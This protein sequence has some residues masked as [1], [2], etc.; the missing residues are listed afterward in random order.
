MY[1]GFQSLRYLLLVILAVA[2]AAVLQD[3]PPIDGCPP[4]FIGNPPNCIAPQYISPK[5]Q[6][7]MCPIGYLG[8]FPDCQMTESAINSTC[9]LYSSGW[10][11]NCQPIPCPMGWSGSFQ[12][13]CTERPPCP[14][15]RPDGVW[16][17]CKDRQ[18]C[19]LNTVGLY[20]FCEC[21]PGTVGQPPNCSPLLSLELQ[22]PNQEY[23]PPKLPEQIPSLLGYL[24]PT[25]TSPDPINIVGYLP[26]TTLQPEL[27]GYLPPATA[28]Q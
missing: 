17:Y 13:Y 16:P 14:A 9:P 15:D 4:P 19:P 12:P 21:A 18:I 25:T 10:P 5:P 8:T 3:W 7:Q 1:L 26:P 2:D 28:D 24:P 6:Y 22:P 27:L 11:P 23:L 20:P